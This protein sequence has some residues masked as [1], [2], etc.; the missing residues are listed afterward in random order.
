MLIEK[1]RPLSA[2]L[3]RCAA[4]AAVV[5]WAALLLQ[6]WLTLGLV[7]GQ[8][9]GFAMGLVVYFGFFTV[10]TNLLAALCLTALATGATGATGSQFA[11]H[12]SLSHPVTTSTAA[13]AITM[14][15]LVYFLVL[16]HTWKPEGA[17]FVADAALHYVNPALMVL[18]WWWAVPAGAIKRTEIAG[19]L[20]YPLAYLIYVFIRGEIVG[21]YP[22]FFIDVG[23]LGYRTA[24]LNSLG[25]LV[26]YA[27]VAVL[28][29]ALKRGLAKPKR[30]PGDGS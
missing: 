10:L 5:V 12:R 22:Y 23:Q 4:A 18:L 24:A 7:I 27:A 14:V 29:M 6:L 3:R 21:L 19:L 16:R 28:F 17:Q 30:R 15:G 2:A 25:V 1:I 13:V 11:V 8:G 9:R 20:A 26:A